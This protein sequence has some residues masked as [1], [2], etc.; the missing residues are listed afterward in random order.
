MRFGPCRNFPDGDAA[1]ST[2]PTAVAM[3][4]RTVGRVGAAGGSADRGR[5]HRDV[6]PWSAV[7]GR[8]GINC[9]RLPDAPVPVLNARRPLLP[10]P[11][12][13]EDPEREFAGGGGGRRVGGGGLGAAA[14]RDRFCSPT[15]SS[16]VRSTPRSAGKN[17]VA[18][19]L[20]S[21]LRASRR[22]VAAR[23]K[24]PTAMNDRTAFLPLR[25]RRFA[26]RK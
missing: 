18:S 15:A 23:E 19:R 6:Y 20:Q 13:P 4:Y 1:T 26:G 7:R 9:P 22:T 5:A 21:L 16:A 14:S 11:E 2:A 3:R 25:R 8:A 24:R 12:E 17:C 10:P